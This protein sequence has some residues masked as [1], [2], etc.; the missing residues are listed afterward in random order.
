MNRRNFV[1]FVGGILGSFGMPSAAK[2]AGTSQFDRFRKMTLKGTAAMPTG[3]EAGST[4]YV[5][6]HQADTFRL[7]LSHDG[8]PIE[9]ISEG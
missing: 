8:P 1:G 4:Y 6:Y 5:V 3:L 7:S 2:Q 9:I